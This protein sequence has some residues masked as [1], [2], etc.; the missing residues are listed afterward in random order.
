MNRGI[1]F[2]LAIASLLLTGACGGASGSDTEGAGADSA[3]SSE[4]TPELFTVAGELT[5]IDSGLIRAEGACTGDG[6]Y[7]DISA[8]AA[9]IIRDAQGQQVGLGELMTGREIDSVTCE[10]SFAVTDVPDGGDKYSIEVSDRGQVPFD[11]EEASDVQIS[12]S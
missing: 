9:I 11:R 8:G 4:P 10:F 5:L 6:G 1:R 7:G 12:L 3:A 2:G